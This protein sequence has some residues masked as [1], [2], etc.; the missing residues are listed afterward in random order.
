MLL[1]PTTFSP[2]WS[3]GLVALRSLVGSKGAVGKWGLT[4]ASF[5]DMSI[6]TLAQR[7]AAGIV[8]GLAMLNGVE[9]TL[10]R[11]V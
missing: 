11:D 1:T 5:T 4:I 7:P 6:P 2:R 3:E 9:G 8:P 10:T